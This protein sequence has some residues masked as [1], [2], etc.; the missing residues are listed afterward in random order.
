MGLRAGDYR[1]DLLG[2]AMP[3]CAMRWGCGPRLHSQ[4]LSSPKRDFLAT[5]GKAV[6]ALVV[7]VVAVAVAV[8]AAEV[9]TVALLWHDDS[10]CGAA[11]TR[12]V[13]TLSSHLL[14]Y[15]SAT[16]FRGP[17]CKLLPCTAF[18]TVT[19]KTM[20][21]VHD[22]NLPSAV[23]LLATAYLLFLRNTSLVTP[24]PFCW[25]VGH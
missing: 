4:L 7:A 16:P 9:K 1:F 17:Y 22:C 12:R 19:V 8:A 2:L 11:H 25:H 13:H 20:P 15:C 6:A 24:G 21:R 5:S 3:S 14:F 23:L 18:F 10:S